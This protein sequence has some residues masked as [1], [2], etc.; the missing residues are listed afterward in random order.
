MYDG[1]GVKGMRQ[2]GRWVTENFRYG[3]EHKKRVTKGEKVRTEKELGR[4][5][6]RQRREKRSSGFTQG[7]YSC[8]ARYT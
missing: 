3:K 8:M 2:M 5:E 7:V 4:R 1:K 6:K